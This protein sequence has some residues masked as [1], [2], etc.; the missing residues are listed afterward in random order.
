MRT[1]IAKIP[2]PIAGVA[3]ALTALGNLLAPASETVHLACGFAALALIALLGAKAVL[4][5]GLIRNDLRSSIMA[6]VS[7]AAFMTL[8]QLASYLAPVAFW[9]AYA[10]WVA[11]IVA[12]LM[13]MMWFT[14][15]FIARFKLSEVFPTY[16]ICY[17]GIVVASATSPAFG[18]QA[19]GHMI[20]WFGLACYAV[21]LV[22]VTLRYARHQVPEGARPLFC[23]YTAPMSLS[24]VGY[25]AT[26]ATPNLVFVAVLLG[27]AQALFAVVLFR[28][29]SLLRLK[30]YPSYAAMTFPFVITATALG[31]ALALFRG[32]GVALPAAFDVLFF[33]EAALATVMVTYVLAHYVRFLAQRPAP[34]VPAAAPASAAA[35]PER[36]EA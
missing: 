27:L 21:L 4:F 15:H 26:A 30:F 16:F 36:R 22:V 1:F 17:V 9:P 7:A 31:Q 20:F 5:P 6:S 18:M 33:A 25:L 29:P 19:V 10:L 11:A 35:L 14:G 8:M 32:A 3:L 13:L 24:L 2:L 28:L 34:A 23:I 12:H